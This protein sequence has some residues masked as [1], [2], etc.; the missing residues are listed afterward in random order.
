M[1][2]PILDLDAN[3]SSGATGNGYVT[4]FTDNGLTPG[5]TYTYRVRA[6]NSTAGSP[7]SN[8]ASA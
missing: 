7:F 1:T 3:D 6:D 2:T 8:N 4:T 5:T